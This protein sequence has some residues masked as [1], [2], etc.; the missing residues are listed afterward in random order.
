M[1]GG[2]FQVSP[3]IYPYTCHSQDPDILLQTMGLDEEILLSSHIGR[4]PDDKY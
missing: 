4:V 3:A 2:P 1:A